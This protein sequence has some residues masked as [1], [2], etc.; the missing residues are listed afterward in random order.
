MGLETMVPFGGVTEERASPLAPRWGQLRNRS[1]ERMELKECV[2][3][4]LRTSGMGPDWG[5]GQRD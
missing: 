1:K 3:E 5:L 4:V 2:P